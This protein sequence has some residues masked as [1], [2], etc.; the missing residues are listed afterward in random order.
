MGK[1]M[2]QKE[3]VDARDP[4]GSER[5]RPARCIPERRGRLFLRPPEAASGPEGG[6]G[7]RLP[8][9]M[10]TGRSRA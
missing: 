3:V 8:A 10:E 9:S 2:E 6:D 5:Q 7:W 1:S 4:E